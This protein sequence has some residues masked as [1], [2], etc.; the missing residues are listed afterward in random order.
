M[1]HGV[2]TAA[3]AALSLS[4]N[5][6][7][8]DKRLEVE[9]DG[10]VV[11]RHVWSVYAVSDNPAHVLRAILNHE[12]ITGELS[13]VQHNDILSATGGE[14]GWLPI[15]VTAPDHSANDSYVTITG[16]TGPFANTLLSFNWS[17]LGP[18]IPQDAAWLPQN[19]QPTPFTTGRIKIMQVA[20]SNV[21][22]RG[23]LTVAYS[24]SSSSTVL[25][26]TE[27]LVYAI[28][29]CTDQ[30]EVVQSPNLVPYSLS[31]PQE[32]LATDILPNSQGA[33]LTVRARGQLGTST[34]FL[35]VKVDGTT[36][37]TNVFGAGSGAGSCTSAASEAVFELSA[38]QFAQLTADGELSVRIEPSA[39][40]TSAG[41]ENAE[42][43]IELRYI[44]DSID[45][46]ANGKDDDCQIAE[47]R[48][49]N[50]CNSNG[51]LDSCEAVSQE[52]DCDR[53]GIPD[54]CDLAS[55]TSR[56]SNL[57]GIIDDCERQY[58]DLNLDGRVDGADLAALLALWGFQ[59]PPYG[60]LDGDGQVGGG[61]LAFLL[62]RWGNTPWYSLP[63]LAAVSPSSG[64]TAGGTFITVSGTNLAGTTSVTVG[65]AAATNVQVV[66][67]TTVTAVTP[68]GTA[69]AKDVSVTT[70]SGTATLP[71]SFT[72]ANVTVPTWATL[73]EAAPSADVVTNATLRAAIAATGYPWLV[74]DTATQVEMVLIPPGTFQMGCSPSN[75]YPCFPDENPVH[76]VMLP[77]A[78]Y[79]GRYEVTQAQWTAR[80]G[81]N[82]SN[83]QSAS[84]QVPASQVPNRPVERVSWNAVQGF[85]SATGMRLPTEA[86]WE[87][88]Y[89]AGTT[90]AFHS[91]PG[92]PNGTNNDSLLGNI[93]WFDGSS[94]NQTRPVGQKAANGLGLYDMG[95]NVWEWVSDW[96]SASY[97]ASSPS[98]NPQGPS[99]GVLRMLR[100]GGW[101]YNSNYCRSAVR[102]Y[103]D[104]SNVNASFGF[105]V[106]R[107]PV[108]APTL[109]AV[110]PT[111]GPTT[112]GTT[113]T[114]TGTNL[115]GASS[116]TVGG[117]AATNVQVVNATTVTAVT[118]AGTAGVRDVT[119]TTPGGTATRTGG[120]TYVNV[121][122][123]T[124]A[125]LVQAQPT[126]TDVPL[127]V[128]RDAIIA[129]GYAWRVRDTATQI[130]MVLIPPGTFQ[131]GCSASVE[132]P[133]D[134]DE[135]PTRQVAMT[136]AFYM[137]VYEVT[138]AQWTARMGSNP[139]VYATSPIRPVDS[140]SWNMVQGFLSSTGMRL[141]TE[142]EWEYAY[143][144][145]TGLAFHG[146]PSSLGGN[147]TTAYLATIA[148]FAGN[149]GAEGSPEYGSKIVGLKQPN[150]HGLHDMSGNVIEW[151]NDWYSGNYYSGGP[152]TDPSGPASGT[153]RVL[154]GGGW[155]DPASACRSSERL[156]DDPSSTGLETTWNPYG[157]GFRVA[158]NPIDGPTLAA[159]SPT[160]GPT[161]GGTTI[162]LT[163]TNLLGTTSVTVGGT[164]AT[165]VQVVNATTVTA[166]TPELPTTTGSG[167]VFP[168]DVTV[169]T[170][171]GTAVLEDGFTY[172]LPPPTLFTVSPASGPTTGG[173]LITVSGT[174]LAGTTVVT[175][176]GVPATDV[177][178][179][180]G[181]TVTA[182]TPAGTAGVRDVSVT[183]PSGE[184]TLPGGFAYVTVPSWGSL[185]EA[186]PDPDVV[187]S[188]ALRDAISA[189]GY[190]WRVRDT[191]TQIE[192]VLVPP[193]TYQR[194]CSP[195]N[196]FGCNS[197]ESPVHQVTLTQPFYM[198]RY[199]VTQAQ[200]TA[201]MGSNPSN[202]Q[203]ASAQVPVSQV[204]NR[205]VEWV[206]WTAVQGFLGATGMRL[207]TEAEWEYAYRAGTTTA[208][209]SMPG[210]PNGTSD[211]SLL[212][213]IAWIGSNST[214][215]TR[216][217]G[218]KSA[219]G[220]GLHDMSGNVSEWVGDWIGTYP[221]S[222]VTDPTGPSSGSA[223][224]YRGGGYLDSA[225]CRASHRSSQSVTGMFSDVGFRVVRG[226]QDTLACS[227]SQGW[228]PTFGTVSNPFGSCRALASYDDGSGAA[229]YAGGF[230]RSSTGSLVI[231]LAKWTGSS[232]L[233]LG[234]DGEVAAVVSDST[235]PALYSTNTVV[236]F[237][238]SW[239]YVTQRRGLT[240]VTLPGG[241]DSAVHAF[242]G[243]ND[244]S[245]MALYAAGSFTSVEFPGGAKFDLNRIARWNGSTWLPLGLGLNG[246][247]KALAVFD[248]GSGPALFAAGAFT[249]AGGVSANR[250]AKWNG[251]SWSALGSGL[252]GDVNALAVHND[253]SGSALYAAGTFTSAGGSSASRIA[254][255][256]GSTWSALGS[257]LNEGANA[258]AVYNDGAG[259][260]LYVGG[261]FT[262]AGGS[263][264]LRIAR[265]R[266]GGWSAL[267]AGLNGTVNVMTV[268]S[269]GTRQSLCVGG[270]FANAP[271]GDSHVA[272]W[273]CTQP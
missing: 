24:I 3:V 136:R 95:G 133:C 210:Q 235:G 101:D 247:V 166:V 60:D 234:G 213:N 98:V 145:Q 191:A 66:N 171:G 228:V 40:A 137:G 75:Q 160:S 200:W 147:V 21:A 144:A 73:V 150:G 112:G 99:V 94:G 230:F 43:S 167:G 111:S 123:P 271:S 159:V 189:T 70:P 31:S 55:D 197:N 45:C 35:T 105:R 270:A 107:S 44:R 222:A 17:G 135:S 223:R 69:S 14:G 15:Y 185:L 139:S 71:N 194:G 27:G 211:D 96:Y 120:F 218:Q 103:S 47:S 88:A 78:F 2:F 168:V 245:G 214:G 62:A 124:W 10:F 80:M 116:V 128:I 236:T 59:D 56:D 67:A 125:T 84:A 142:A 198:G 76:S 154:R 72:Y 68:A 180:D 266:A 58:G 109:A 140:V 65:G 114:L 184:A 4:S 110:S 51:I 61:D 205:P 257:G 196:A 83:F 255:W 162:T 153:T 20:G 25:Q 100:G 141:P 63:T 134:S 26:N 227:G 242:I 13:G 252:N 87:Y 155:L 169:T 39:N 108:A 152:N 195:S 132:G 64:P 179:L 143:R 117:A 188:A 156:A 192:F 106:V 260:A 92:Q 34:A 89:R 253:G 33:T 212:G 86:E 161:T 221:S 187:T 220:L 203:S 262:S 18:S 263:S 165:N 48:E 119:V 1:R 254:K 7:S 251:T 38:S 229:I 178:V 207:P 273:G 215:Q 129:S 157:Y 206:S 259:P 50:D 241:L 172:L 113:I 181:V 32:W 41:C 118:P 176:G 267:G 90:T 226:I 82:P 264:A 204:P 11:D 148:W 249:S 138:Q 186:A 158:R 208:F 182:V 237:D 199:E 127:P 121:T 261:D 54:L 244:G 265:W 164:A 9:Y 246:Q 232:W 52:V 149:N 202:F 104:P 219:N 256:N 130:E 46:D 29:T 243:H 190:P 216:P 36:L 238:D 5:A 122:I 225:N 16:L 163:G 6:L 91:M 28:G 173:T 74:R 183:T 177:Q 258:L 102:G 97:Y 250:I 49:S 201:R 217:V 193:G 174:N 272:R 79:M 131:M 126:I 93:T 231:G 57:N 170:A 224:V 81:S 233:A 175:V 77:N 151:V 268:H 85:L 12:V 42:L 8:A 146:S 30:P 23:R 209:H 37:S 115:N 248:D 240:N 22:Y 269:D 239:T 53:N 19:A